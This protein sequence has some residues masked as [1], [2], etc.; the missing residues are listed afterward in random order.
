MVA[1]VAYADAFRAQ[2]ETLLGREL[3]GT[4]RWVALDGDT[5]V[6]YAATWPVHAPKFRIELVVDA[7]HRGR[8]S[9]RHC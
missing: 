6:G 2:A 3:S 7:K 8:G 5:V 1:V 4:Q 9:A